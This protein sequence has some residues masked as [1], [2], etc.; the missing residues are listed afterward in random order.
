MGFSR[1][2]YWSGLSF[3]SPR[4]L[5]NPRIKSL[6]H[7]L[8]DGFFTA[9]PPEKPRQMN[10]W[11]QILAHAMQEKQ[12][13]LWGHRMGRRAFRGKAENLSLKKQSLGLRPEG[14][15]EVR[16]VKRQRNGI[17]SKGS[18][19]GKGLSHWGAEQT[20]RGWVRCDLCTVSKV[21]RPAMWAMGWG[22]P[23]EL[24]EPSEG[25]CRG[26]G[27]GRGQPGPQSDREDLSWKSI[28]QSGQWVTRETNYPCM[29][30]S[31]EISLPPPA[32]HIC[33]GGAVHITGLS[34]FLH[35][36]WIFCCFSSWLKYWV[37]FIYLSVASGTEG[38]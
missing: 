15:N 24:R 9:E 13:F 17:S 38:W 37:V 2:E 3:P 34:L 33:W 19:A 16:P 23:K 30:S 20:L 8:A 7:A 5:P 18:W 35:G 27:G 36:T 14:G 26:L 25:E 28:S 11:L 4:D 32:P 6:S 1:Q 31:T 29:N 12:R 21:V 22:R 10:M